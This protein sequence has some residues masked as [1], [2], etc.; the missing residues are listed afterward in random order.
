MLT[1]NFGNF[2][3]FTKLLD[4]VRVLH[5]IHGDSVN[6]DDSVIF[7]GEGK[8]NHGGNLIQRMSEQ[9]RL[10]GADDN[11]TVVGLLQGPLSARLR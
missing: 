5:V 11:L 6:H 1:H 10:E 4:G 3:T 7:P 8:W 9:T 2:P